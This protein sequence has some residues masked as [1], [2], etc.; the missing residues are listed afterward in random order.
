MFVMRY[1]FKGHDNKKNSSTKRKNESNNSFFKSFFEKIKKIFKGRNMGRK[2]N[3]DT[4]IVDKEGWDG[5]NKYDTNVVVLSKGGDTNKY[6]T[7][8]VFSCQGG[9]TNKY[10]TNDDINIETKGRISEKKFNKEDKENSE[11]NI[12]DSGV[13][14]N[15]LIGMC[16]DMKVGLNNNIN[17]FE[18]REYSWIISMIFKDD[19]G[20]KTS[21]SFLK[22]TLLCQI[23]KEDVGKKGY[24]EIYT[25]DWIIAKS[26]Y[27]VDTQVINIHYGTKKCNMRLSFDTQINKNEKVGLCIINNGLYN[28]DS[29]TV[30][31]IN[32]D[33]A[34]VKRSVKLCV[35][36]MN[37]GYKDE[38]KGLLFISK[39]PC[40]ED[41]PFPGY[42][43][44]LVISKK[45]KGLIV[46][47]EEISLIT[48]DPITWFE[49]Y[50]MGYNEEDKI[51]DSTQIWQFGDGEKDLF[52][53]IQNQTYLNDNSKNIFFTKYK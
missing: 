53:V 11:F 47:E 52:P 9:N 12:F 28:E 16:K 30:Y 49:K 50:I 40:D 8:V 25:E 27:N 18:K 46:K 38:I 1:F 21:N 44:S 39:N 15:K 13:S 43:S 3:T 45:I 20:D 19:N 7:N 32:L 36:L 6:D 41:K 42:I 24:M 35:E 10:D 31:T 34:E 14:L 23:D 22:K 33:T 5:M 4:N 26:K 2:Y 17:L 48:I 51:A 29:F 37:G